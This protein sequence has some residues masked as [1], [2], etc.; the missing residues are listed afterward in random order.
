MPIE[1]R[2]KDE[3]VLLLF[4]IDDSTRSL[5]S[6]LEAVEHVCRGRWAFIV[7]ADTVKSPID[8]DGHGQMASDGEIADLNRLRS[9]LKDVAVR[10]GVQIY[11]AVEDAVTAITKLHRNPLSAGK[12]HEEMIEIRPSGSSSTFS[13]PDAAA[14]AQAEA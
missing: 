2:A 10:H 9:Y 8:F 7:M 1:A 3:C 14:V 4:V 5:V 12:Q 13:S 11:S 6:V